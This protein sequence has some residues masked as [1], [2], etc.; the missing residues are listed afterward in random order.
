MNDPKPSDMR[1]L[2][3]G[4]PQQWDGSEWRSLVCLPSRP[5][6]MAAFFTSAEVFDKWDIKPI[7]ESEWGD[8]ADSDLSDYQ[9]M[10]TYDQNGTGSCAWEAITG[11]AG[12]CLAQQTGELITF[13]PWCGYAQ[14]NS[15]D[16]GS[17]VAENAQVA[18]DVG[19]IRDADWPRAKHRWNTIPPSYKKLANPYRVDEVFRITTLSD[20]VTCVLL[21]IPVAFGVRW[22][23]GG[24]AIRATRWDK[25][26]NGCVIKNSWGQWNGGEGK[27]SYGFLPRKQVAQ[28][29]GIYSAMAIRSFKLSTEL[30]P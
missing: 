10:H 25:S 15:R 29:I 18:R 5:E 16:I 30:T 1:T 12:D 21:R 23:G 19:L 17:D 2:D 9:D 6:L 27:P 28:G 13:N 11:A 24:H 14:T 3:D 20:F 7:P 26:R 4:T 8:Y 22:S